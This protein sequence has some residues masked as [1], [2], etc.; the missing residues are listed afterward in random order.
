M[1][2]ACQ[3][4]TSQA[5]TY[6]N[7]GKTTAFFFPEVLLHRLLNSYPRK[8]NGS[9]FNYKLQRDQVQNSVAPVSFTARLIVF[10]LPS[11]LTSGI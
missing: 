10:T 6:L 11:N 1:W 5:N 8:P 4:N 3:C 9:K 7:L 2:K